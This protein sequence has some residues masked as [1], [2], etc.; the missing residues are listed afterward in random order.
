IERSAENGIDVFRIFDALNDLRNLE[1]AV[2]ATLRA[3]K[4]A[5]GTMSYTISPVHTTDMWVEL[6]KRLEDMGCHSVCIKDMAGLLKPYAAYEIVSRLKESLR[7][8]VALH[9]HATTGMSTASPVKAAEAG[10]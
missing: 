6:G 7:I 3:G 5:Q 1:S 10:L 8:P 9:S 4:H 2:R